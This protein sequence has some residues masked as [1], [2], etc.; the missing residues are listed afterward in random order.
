MD[1]QEKINNYIQRDTFAKHL[2]ASVEILGTGHSRATVTV[3]DDMLNFHGSAHGGLI[4]TL[5]DIAFAAACNSS[6]Q[7]AVALNVCIN[8]LKAVNTGDTLVAEA[9]ERHAEG[10]TGL[11][12]V[13]VKNAATGELVAVSQDLAYRKKH[14]FVTGNR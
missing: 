3:T 10:P 5:G 7:T 4:F 13:T 1:K 2:G 11:C 12:D 9:I 14:W 8:F 6:G